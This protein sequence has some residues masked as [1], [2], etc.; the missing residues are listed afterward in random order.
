MVWN[1]SGTVLVPFDFGDSSHRAVDKALGLVLNPAQ[2]HI[3]HAIPAFIPLAPEGMPIEWSDDQ[4]RV[5]QSLIALQ[6]EFKDERYGALKLHVLIGDPASVCTEYAAEI[7]AELI[8][9]PSHGRTGL[10]RLILGSVAEG[11]LRHSKCPVLVLK[12]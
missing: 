9:I 11:I 6:N 5:E 10:A 8:V 2:V 1:I 7:G 4:Q 3:V 12:I